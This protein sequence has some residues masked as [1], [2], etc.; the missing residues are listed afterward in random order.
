MGPEECVGYANSAAA[1][2]RLST[3]LSDRRVA[4]RPVRNGHMVPEEAEAAA[5]P[6]VAPSDVRAIPL[7]DSAWRRTNRILFHS[8][9]N[10]VTFDP[11]WPLCTAGRRCPQAPSRRPRRVARV[12]VK[13]Y[14]R[15]D[16]RP[17]GCARAASVRPRHRDR[18]GDPNLAATSFAAA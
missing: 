15:R 10:G 17:E 4:Q 9:E 14:N 12:L 16:R 13:T 18:V 1:M 6:L 2:A 8:D 11:P 5:V 7:V 3:R